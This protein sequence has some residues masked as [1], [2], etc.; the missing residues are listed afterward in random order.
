M[1]ALL[2]AAYQDMI[3][4]QHQ[5]YQEIARD[6]E[7]VGDPEHTQQQLTRIQQTCVAC[8][9]AYRFSR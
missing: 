1:Q 7:A 4:S 8:H 2:P 5:A 6:A 9:S 3:H